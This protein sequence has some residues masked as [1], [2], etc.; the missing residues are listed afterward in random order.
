MR[1]TITIVAVTFATIFSSNAQEEKTKPLH[2]NL[3]R[4]E[5]LN[6]QEE[7]PETPP[8]PVKPDELHATTK[9][10]TI[11]PVAPVLTEEEKMEVALSR[12]PQG[13]NNLK[14][15]LKA[16]AS[17]EEYAAAKEQLY[18]ENPEKYQELFGGDKQQGSGPRKVSRAK[19]D[20]MPK[21]TRDYID[22]HPDLYQI[23]D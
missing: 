6:V 12:T 4:S 21:E 5:K 20:A 22:A 15:G 16:S 17:K 11:A 13:Q 14:L 1:T 23:V 7:E 2:P 18:V 3:A 10:R 9:Q 19:Y 8:T